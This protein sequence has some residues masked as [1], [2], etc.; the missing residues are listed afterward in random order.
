MK[1]YFKLISNPIYMK[2]KGS[3]TKMDEIYQIFQYL[4]FTKMKKFQC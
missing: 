3:H 4:N 2:N 1:F